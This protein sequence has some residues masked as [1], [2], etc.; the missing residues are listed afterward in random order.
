MLRTLSLIFLF[1]FH[2]EV[3]SQND[4]LNIV[5]EPIDIENLG[6]IQA[7]A[8]GQSSGQWLIIGGRLDGLHRRQPFAAFDEAGHNKLLWVIN[9][10]TASAWN[11]PLTSLPEAMQEQLSS[12]NMEFHQ[13]E[14]TLYVIGGYGFSATAN[15]HITYP[16]MTAIDVPEVIDAIINNNP[17]DNYFRQITDEAFRVT[18]GHLDRIDD[19]YYISGGQNFEG[20]YNPMGPDF[21][22]GFVQE[23][24]NSIRRFTIA[25]DGENIAVTHLPDWFDEDNLH[26]RDYNVVPQIMPDGSTGF[27]AFSGVFQASVDLPFLNCVNVTADAYEVNNDF[28]QYYNHYHCANA[29]LFSVNQNKMYNLFFGGIAQFYDDN[30]TIVQDDNVPFVKTIGLVTRDNTGTMAEFKLENEMPGYLGSSSEFI[31]LQNIPSFENNVLDYDAITEDTTHIGYIFGGISSSALNIFFTNTGVESEASSTIY[32]VYLV[33]GTEV[34]VPKLNENSLESLQLI[35]YPNP[36]ENS[37]S[38]QYYLENASDVELSIF[39]TQGNCE[40]RKKLRKQPSGEQ[41][42][43]VKQELASGIHVINIKTENASSTQKIIIAK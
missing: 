8:F 14:N 33:K 11:A 12:T 22:P 30:G 41:L 40:F 25:D 16:N 36:T 10:S 27:T 21:G 13:R 35:T 32:E 39:D 28:S 29:P 4:G 19:T 15:D 24:T 34:S 5:L 18:G 38:V 7:F 2:L 26:R 23:Y 3:K 43:E 9:P 1:L 42:Y 6:G 37:F 20:R 17:F 31:A